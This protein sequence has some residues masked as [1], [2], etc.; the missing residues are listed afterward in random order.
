MPAEEFT[1]HM[2]HNEEDSVGACDIYEK[3]SGVFE[4]SLA[5]C[6]KHKHLLVLHCSLQ[7]TDPLAA[8]F[9]LWKLLFG[10]HKKAPLFF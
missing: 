8:C 2:S 5:T 3:E 10:H 1:D 4:H 6:C 7:C 9:L